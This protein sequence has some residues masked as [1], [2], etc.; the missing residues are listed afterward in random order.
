MKTTSKIKMTWEQRRPQNKLAPLLYKNITCNFLMILNRKC[1]QV[2]KPE[3]ELGMINVIY[4]VLP[5]CAQTEK[6]TFSCK[7]NCILTKHT[8][9]WIYYSGLRYFLSRSNLRCLQV[10]N[11][12]DID[13]SLTLLDEPWDDSLF[14]HS[15]FMQLHLS[16]FC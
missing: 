1:Y 9:R 15:L 3:M 4:A 12:S 2:S 16:F 11:I 5:M 8:R 14:L 6:I 7:D 13:F 10:L